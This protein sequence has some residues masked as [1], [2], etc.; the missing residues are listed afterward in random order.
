MHKAIESYIEVATARLDAIAQQV[1][2][3]R[4]NEALITG[5]FELAGGKGNV[6]DA[7]A[8]YTSVAVTGF[9]AS[10]NPTL[11]DTITRITQ[12]L[13]VDP[14]SYAYQGAECQVYIWRVDGFNFKLYATLR[15]E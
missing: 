15:G 2:T 1:R 10:E 7:Y 6:V 3:V 14:T 11:A 8:A 5:F 13:G 9:L 12:F 4:A